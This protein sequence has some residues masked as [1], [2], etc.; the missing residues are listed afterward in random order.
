MSLF[1]GWL[2]RRS[3]AT[4]TTP[5]SVPARPNLLEAARALAREGKQQ[6]ASDTYW[7]I[8]R[9]H[10]TVAGL[11]EHAQLLFELG[12][13]FGAASR[14]SGALELE[15]GNAEAQAI[16]GRGQKATMPK[17]RVHRSE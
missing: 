7:K 13:M 10:H 9:K 11:I 2:S 3:G 16:Q 6:E 1:F 17:A 5:E 8:K 15:P 14:A 12:D 4:P